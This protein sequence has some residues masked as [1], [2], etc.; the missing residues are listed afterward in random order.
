[1]PL[2]YFH[3]RDGTDTVVDPKGSVMTADA[4]PGN[5]LWQARD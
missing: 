4:V 1:M 5:A 2:Y 3:L